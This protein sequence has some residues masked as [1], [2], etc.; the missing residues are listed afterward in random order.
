MYLP[1]TCEDFM[2]MDHYY[3]IFLHLKKKLLHGRIRPYRPCWYNF[4]MG[5]IKKAS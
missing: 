4:G 5:A 2:M 1:S 3:Y